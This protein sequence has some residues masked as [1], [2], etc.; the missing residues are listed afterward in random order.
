MTITETTAATPAAPKQA[1]QEI[2]D[3]SACEIARRIAARELS[4]ADTLERFIARLEEVDGKLNAVTVDLFASAR[5]TA[6]EVDRALARGEK[7]PP[8]AGVPVTIKEC[9]DLSG[10]AS[11]LGLSSRRDILE[12]EDDPY[13]AAL[14]AAG[15]IP[16]AKTNLPQL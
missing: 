8:L 12:S 2:A 7:L 15:A 4:A 16:M 6:A 11:T 1:K 5:K 3:V 14:R 10:T 13:I 9:F